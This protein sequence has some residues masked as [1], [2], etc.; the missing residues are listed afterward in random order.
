MDSDTSPVDE[1][2]EMLLLSAM[3]T[4]VPELRLHNAGALLRVSRSCLVIKKSAS[5]FICS[6]ANFQLLCKLTP[7]SRR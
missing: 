6:T 4:P 2:V 7:W 5:D 3:E 1:F